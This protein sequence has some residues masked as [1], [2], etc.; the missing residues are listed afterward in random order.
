MGTGAAKTTQSLFNLSNT[1]IFGDNAVLVMVNVMG[2]WIGKIMSVSG[3]GG[4]TQSALLTGNA[5]VAPNSTTG[6]DSN[7]QATTT[8]TNTAN[9]NQSTSGTITNNINVNAQSGDASATDNT[10]VGNVTSGNANATSS[11]ANI[12]NSVLNVK[13]WFGV[14]VIN[15]FGSWTGDVNNNTS[16]GDPVGK[17]SGAPAPTGTHSG[18]VTVVAA[19]GSTAARTFAAPA[20][21]LAAP[22]TVVTSG[23]GAA[24]KIA[25]HVPSQAAALVQAQNM[26]LVFILSA[27]GLLLAGAMMSFERRLRRR[28]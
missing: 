4:T 21:V 10:K 18:P 24:V 20:A 2:H 3:L 13:H 23:A 25:A 6:P 12:V 9:I 17:P 26:S 1:S 15:V 27:I 16:A 19:F 22:A 8:N 5:S 14:L 7:N 11:V 28:G